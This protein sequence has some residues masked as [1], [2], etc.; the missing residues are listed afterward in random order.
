MKRFLIVIAIA[1]GAFAA[2]KEAMPD[3][4][5]TQPANS[6]VPKLDPPQR[7]PSSTPASDG[8]K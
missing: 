4:G 5:P 8:G 2:C 7:E 6:P 3:D 1:A